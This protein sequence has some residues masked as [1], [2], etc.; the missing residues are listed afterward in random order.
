M[1]MHFSHFLLLYIFP[2]IVF[3][4]SYLLS[5]RVLT[6]S[7]YSMTSSIMASGA[8]IEETYL[9]RLFEPYRIFSSVLYHETLGN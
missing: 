3:S 5:V 7:G 1:Y 6:I 8:D 9:L 4:V 2:R